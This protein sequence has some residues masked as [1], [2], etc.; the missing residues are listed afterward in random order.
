WRRARAHG[1]GRAHDGSRDDRC[2]LRPLAGRA[3]NYGELKSAVIGES[4]RPDLSAEAP[5]FIRRAESMIARNLRA[6][7]MIAHAKLDDDARLEGAVYAL[8]ID[9]LEARAF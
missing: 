2:G 3:M 4:H 9:F 5:T 6:A 8:P 1:G 7:E